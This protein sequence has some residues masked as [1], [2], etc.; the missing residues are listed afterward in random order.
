VANRLA[1][2]AAA[3]AGAIGWGLVES[4]WVSRRRIDVLPGAPEALRGRTILHLSDLHAGTPSLGLVA[5]RKAVDFGV[6]C[7]PDLVAITGD[8]LSHARARAAVVEQIARLRPP[9]GTFAVLGN[10][11]IGASN[12][13]FSRGALIDDWGDA[14]VT[15]LRDQAVTVA[16]GALEIAGLDP[17]SWLAGTADAPA[18][19]S[20]PGAFRLLLCH[21]PEAAEELEPGDADLVLCGHLHGGQICLPTPCGKLRMAHGVRRYREGVYPGPPMVV[22]SRGLGTTLLPI[23]I[24]ARP[25][26][27][28]LRLGP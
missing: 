16:G 2:F 27:T 22:V 17:T 28:L 21:F 24:G 7:R 3:A 12:D 14:P 8:I 4:Q 26:V 11:D 10:H 20:A 25:E 5:L 9:L 13:P 23:R 18:L 1:P 15:V 6:E 19:F